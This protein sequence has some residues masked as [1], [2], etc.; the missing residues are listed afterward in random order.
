MLIVVSLIGILAASV[1]PSTSPSLHEQLHASAQVVASDLAYARSLAVTNNSQYR[2]TFN[3]G[4]N[5]YVLTHTG[6]SSTL[7]V[8]PP[9]PFR[10]SADVATEHTVTLSELPQLGTPAVL[11]AVHAGVDSPS[12]TTTIEFNAL[13]G[14]TRTQETVIWLGAGA[15][16][17]RCYLSVRV[18][19]ITGLTWIENYQAAAPPLAP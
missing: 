17:D 15:G 13:G 11:A 8:L 6:A 2:I 5:S 12:S 1:L 18:N 3:T 14:T 9:S 19:P 16:G 4:A 10:S 7:D